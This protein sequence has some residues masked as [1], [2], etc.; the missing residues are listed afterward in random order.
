MAQS[1]LTGSWRRATAALHGYSCSSPKTPDRLTF[2]PS[3]NHPAGALE[4]HA[5]VSLPPEKRPDFRWETFNLFNRTVFGAGSTNIN[6]N[7]FSMVANQVNDPRQMQVALK[8]SW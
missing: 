2:D 6:R 3:S 4:N 7:A 1:I 5:F 8:L